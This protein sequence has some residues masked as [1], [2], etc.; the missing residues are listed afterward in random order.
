MT[1]LKTLAVSVFLATMALSAA[2]AQGST[3]MIIDDAQIL[4]ASKAGQDI[5]RK[6]QAIETQINNELEPSRKALENQA[7]ALQ[8]RLEGKTR[9]QIAADSALVSE[10]GAFQQSQQEFN[11]ERAVAARE[12]ALTEEKAI[13]DFNKAL[14][15]ALLEVVQEKNAQLVLLR[16]QAVFAADSVDGTM[17]VVQRL[18]QKTPAIAVTRQKLPANQP[19][20]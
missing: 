16:S 13:I 2:M 14:E 4:R 7:K 3:V 12:F 18:D 8:P 11:Q 20:N 15:P 9:E 1:F 10:L 19:A 17:V 5:A 6:L